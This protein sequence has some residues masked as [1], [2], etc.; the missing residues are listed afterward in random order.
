MLALIL[1]ETSC[2]ALEGQAR[3]VHSQKTFFLLKT[4]R[5]TQ[6]SAP[7]QSLQREASPPLLS[8]SQNTDDLCIRNRE[9]ETF[10]K[11]CFHGLC[12]FLST[13]VFYRSKLPISVLGLEK[14]QPT[15]KR[16]P[17]LSLQEQVGDYSKRICWCG[18]TAAYGCHRYQ[19]LCS[20][21]SLPVACAGLLPL[22][23]TT[24]LT[25]CAAM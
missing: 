3:S 4:K 12:Y 18:T 11:Y 7:Q 2:L 22:I 15:P 19:L 13:Q 21:P 5:S 8:T 25:T 10:L 17:I 1:V 9:G 16:Q 14:K 20:W 24:G 23:A 6:P